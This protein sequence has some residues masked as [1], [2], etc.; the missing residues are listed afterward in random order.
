MRYYQGKFTP[1]NK[2]KY[3]GNID[4]IYYRSSLELQLFIWCDKTDGIKRWSS[5]EIVIPYRCPIDQKQHRYFIDAFIEFDNGKKMLV[6]IKPDKFTKPPKPSK[7]KR[8]Y[9]KESY[10]YVR[11]MAK[12]EAAESFANK[13]NIEFKVWTEK[14]L[15]SLGIL[16]GK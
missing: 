1:K 10:D 12:W 2:H 15:K 4:M 9:M 6:E 7:S 16:V 11:N 8:K 13:N 14:T 5:E 3:I